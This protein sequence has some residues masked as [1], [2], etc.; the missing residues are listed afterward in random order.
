M[1]AVDATGLPLAGVVVPASM[2]ENETTRVMLDHLARKG[3][4]DRLE[5]LLVDRG[6]TA[7]AADKLGRRHGVGA[8]RCVHGSYL[9]PR[10]AVVAV[11]ST[12]GNSYDL[13]ATGGG[14]DNR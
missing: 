12:I 5:L 13:T 4:T 9:T 3:V 2:H 14:S 8:A 10:P 6:V 7:R 11:T 1:V